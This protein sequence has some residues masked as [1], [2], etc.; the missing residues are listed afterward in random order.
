MD[1]THEIDNGQTR[2]W[3]GFAGRAWVEAQELLDQMFKPFEDLL[4]E[5]APTR[6]CMGSSPQA[7]T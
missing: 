6:R 2:V 3:N 5:A 7:S 4:V 1:V